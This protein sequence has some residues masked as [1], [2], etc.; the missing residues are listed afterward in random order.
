[1]HVLN[2]FYVDSICRLRVDL[3][4]RDSYSYFLLLF[5]I[6]QCTIMEIHIFFTLCQ[7]PENSFITFCEMKE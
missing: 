6:I 3:V 7:Q 5:D 2:F 1:M 4:T